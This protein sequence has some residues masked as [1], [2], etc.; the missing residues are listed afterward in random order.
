[1]T[2]FCNLK[3]HF[4]QFLAVFSLFFTG[5]AFCFFEAH[6]RASMPKMTAKWSSNRNIKQ[7]LDINGYVR[8]MGKKRKKSNFGHYLIIFVILA[9]FGHFGVHMTNS[10]GYQPNLPQIGYKFHILIL[11]DRPVI[12]TVLGPWYLPWSWISRLPKKMAPKR[13]PPSSLTG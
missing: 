12:L 1:M 6:A 9:K 4:F 10:A 8:T 7:I 2:P 13:H 3:R 11:H 5:F